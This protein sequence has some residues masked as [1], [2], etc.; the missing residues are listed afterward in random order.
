MKRSRTKNA[1]VHGGI[2]KHK[3]MNSPLIY[4]SKFVETS[5]PIVYKALCKAFNASGIEHRLLPHSMDIWTR[6]FMP[7]HIGGSQYITFRYEPDYLSG[8]SRKFITDQRA[9]I[10]GLDLSIADPLDV[11]LDGGNY[12]RCGDKVLMT[13]KLLMENASFTP[14]KLLAR[15][16]KAF[17]AE[18]ILLPWDMEEPYGHADGMVSYLGEGRL[19]LN[20]YRQFGRKAIPFA[21]RLRRILEAQFEVVEAYYEG[22]PNSHSWC[23]LN[24]LETPKTILLPGLS[25]DSHCDSDQAA[26]SFFQQIFPSK[27]IVQVYAAPLIKKGGAIHCITWEHFPSS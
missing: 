22:K 25:K 19:L 3:A 11:K 17:Q 10:D 14:R 26:L 5:Y 13:D 27:Q 7:I 1:I 24:Y 2:V 6:D 4:L 16:E 21:N 20:N 23:Y 12:V 15:L 8:K 9:A 18:L